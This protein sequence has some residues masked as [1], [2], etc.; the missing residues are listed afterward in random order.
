MLGGLRVKVAGSVRTEGADFFLSSN[1]LSSK[2]LPLVTTSPLDE[3]LLGLVLLLESEKE[4]GEAL[5]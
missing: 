5:T 1:L 3:H 4:W 2:D